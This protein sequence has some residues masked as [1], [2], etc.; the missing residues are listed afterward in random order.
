[1]NVVF[2]DFVELKRKSDDW[3]LNESNI[4]NLFYITNNYWI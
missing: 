1:M 3:I 2:A 4:A